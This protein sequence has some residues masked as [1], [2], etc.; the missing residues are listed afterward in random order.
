MTRLVLLLC[1][2]FSA[3]ITFQSCEDDEETP[4]GPRTEIYISD[5]GNFDKGPWQIL[6][7][8][9]NGGNPQ[10]FTKTNVSWPQDI[11][12]LEDQGIALVSNANTGN[13]AKFA[14]EDGKFLGNFAT[15]MGLPNRMKIRD[16][17]IYVLQWAGNMKVR[18]FQFDG[19]MVD[20]FTKVGVFQA[21][22]FDWDTDGNMYV[23]SF[24]QGANGFVQKF[25]P[26]GDDLGVFID[27]SLQGPTNIWFDENGNLIVNDWQSG[28]IKLFDAT[29]AFVKN[30]VTGLSQVEGV[31]FLDNGNI[32]IGNGG[33][34][35][36]KMYDSN[37]KF[38]KDLVPPKSGGLL[39]PNAVV[40]RKVQ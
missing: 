15:G 3:A 4:S 8:D 23:S 20:D 27:S 24:N 10:V 17:M 22:G 5:A 38:L 13:I 29:G 28:Q 7:Y 31:D 16:N 39:K 37:F 33:S 32:L 12:F 21:I 2:L 14:I 6:K 30:L 26:T 36:I 40:I 1:L 34:G 35:A 19:I 9:E 18:R 25:S 11:L